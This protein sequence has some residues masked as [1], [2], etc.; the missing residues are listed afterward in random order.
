[1]RGTPTE[2]GETWQLA[3]QAL[4]AHKMRAMLTMLGVVIGRACI[5]L[6]VTVALAGKRY[7]IGQIEA[8]GANLV[9]ADVIHTGASRPLT[10]SDEITSSDLDAIKQSIPAVVEVAGTNDM[11]L[12]LSVEGREHPINLVGVTAGFQKL[13]NLIILQGRYL[14]QDDLMTQSKVCLLT[15]Q[16][17]RSGVPFGKPARKRD[18]NRR[19]SLHGHWR[20]Q[21]ARMS[22]FGQTE[23]RPESVIIPFSLIKCYSG[24]EFFKND[25]RAG[26]PS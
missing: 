5:V 3:W 14:D 7:I 8:V 13:R 22:T 16:L 15:P 1:M 4:R 2:W 26:G 20:F 12:S 25:L 21:R 10:L 17:A 18:R 9:Y 24:T 11:P 23:I 19:T 6:V